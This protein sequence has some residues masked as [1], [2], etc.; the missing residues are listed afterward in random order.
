MTAA[1]ALIKIMIKPKPAG[2]KDNV[3]RKKTYNN[4]PAVTDP[5][6]NI[7]IS[8]HLPDVAKPIKAIIY[9]PGLMA[10]TMTAKKIVRKDSIDIIRK[11]SASPLYHKQDLV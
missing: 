7:I 3:V 6:Q 1:I 10:R 2:S 5:N 11:L 9:G 4:V 8:F